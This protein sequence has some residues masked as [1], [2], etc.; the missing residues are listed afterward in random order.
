MDMGEL[1]KRVA[2]MF[3]YGAGKSRILKLLSNE[4]R[5]RVM[6]PVHNTPDMVDS[7]GNLF[8]FKTSGTKTGRIPSHYQIDYYNAGKLWTKDD[9]K[10][11]KVMFENGKSMHNMCKRL[12]RT[13]CSLESRLIKMRLIKNKYAYPWARRS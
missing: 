13:K 6:E 4:R 5:F 2:Y 11:L 12:G 9:E 3:A 8:E 10:C 7:Q 1:E